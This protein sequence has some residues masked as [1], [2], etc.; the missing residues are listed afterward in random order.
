M[1]VSSII[2]LF[3]FCLDELSIDETEVWKS[4]TNVWIV[5]YDLHV[6]NVS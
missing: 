1:I 3:N 4:S 2:F 5:M 6:S